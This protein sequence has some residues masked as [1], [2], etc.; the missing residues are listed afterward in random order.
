[1]KVLT[2]S[3]ID[4]LVVVE[5]RVVAP[6]YLEVGR[7]DVNFRCVADGTRVWQYRLWCR[8][9]ER[10][11]CPKLK[12]RSPTY[13]DA[14]CCD[15]WFSFATF[16]EWCNKEVGYSGKP[17]GMHLDKDLL[18]KG[19]KVY[20]PEACSFVPQEVNKLLNSCASKRGNQPIGVYFH[21]QKERYIA[22]LSCSG[23]VQQ[24]GAFKTAEEAF[25]A[26][27]IAKE[28]Q[29][30]ATALRHKDVLKP[31]VFESLMNWEVTP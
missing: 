26:Y 25:A 24:L 9:L 15:E 27:K 14:T 2:Q 5:R 23:Q 11:C 17:V 16:L 19:N 1:M 29:V 31:A 21:N 4:K 6:T 13:Q 10:A 20:S 8:V 3:E 22:K 30:K 7:N 28:D 12:Q 18:I